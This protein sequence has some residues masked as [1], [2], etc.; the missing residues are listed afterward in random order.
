MK[1]EV[2]SKEDAILHIIVG[3]F[4]GVFLMFAFLYF[5]WEPA[6]YGVLIMAGMLLIAFCMGVV[7]FCFYMAYRG[8]KHLRSKD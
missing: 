7:V 8:Y 6:L 2:M 5:F 3:T 1:E 4:L